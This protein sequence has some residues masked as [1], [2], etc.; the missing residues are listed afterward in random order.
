MYRNKKLLFLCSSV[1]ASTCALYKYYTKIY[2]EAE[3]DTDN[4]E[5]KDNIIDKIWKIEEY[6]KIVERIKT[7]SIEL[8]HDTLLFSIGDDYV[9]QVVENIG[10]YKRYL[11][12]DLQEKDKEEKL[13]NMKNGLF[14]VEE[15][16]NKIL[17][18]IDSSMK[19]S[20][21]HN[22]LDILGNKN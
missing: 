4:D 12:N 9:I 18:I 1:I 2:K 15:T 3:D 10:G 21:I 17:K 5:C 16:N 11:F 7:I 6:N 13:F 14:L 20:R 19:I 8:P 22:L